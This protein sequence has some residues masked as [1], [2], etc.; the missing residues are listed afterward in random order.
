[1][2]QETP[3]NKMPVGA[4][5]RT[6]GYKLKDKVKY[7]DIPLLLVTFVL[8]IFGLIMIT[9]A[10]SGT[11]ITGEINQPWAFLKPQLFS[12]GLGLVIF[13]IMMA[14]PQQ[15]L[16]NPLLHLLAL[17]I[18]F[19]LLIYTAFAGEVR[20]GA[21]SWIQVGSFSLQIS[22]YLKPIAVLVYAWV[23]AKLSEEVRLFKTQ[24]LVLFRWSIVVLSILC[25]FLIALQPDFGMV[26]IILAIIII[27]ILVSKVSLKINLALLGIGGLAYAGLLIYFSNYQGQSDS[28]Q[29]NRFL[30]MVNPFNFRQGI[31]YQLV[32]GYYA[33]SRGGWFGVG[34]GQGQMKNGLLPEIQT[35]FIFAHIGE[36]LGIFGLAFLLGLFAFL[37]YRLFYWAGQAQSQF[38]SLVLF[39]LGVLFFIQIT[40]NVGGVLGL[41][42][43]TGV[44]LPFISYGGS[45]V[46]NFMLTLALAQKMIYTEKRSRKPEI[47]VVYSRYQGG[48]S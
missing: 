47:N 24:H 22:E 15:W 27:M 5:I 19:L 3:H 7:F 43:L 46:L 32:N 21:K 25:L 8:I 31:G 28:Y 48:K 16:A 42:P 37:L 29:I 12:V 13:L 45:S 23:L 26:A 14:V 33:M 11:S 20:N 1:M 10:T 17:G 41:I 9:S 6:Y 36:E 18:V 44:T 2:N 39:G 4:L 38:S 30:A 40:V 34:L 35:D